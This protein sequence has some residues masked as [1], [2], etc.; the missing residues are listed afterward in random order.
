MAKKEEYRISNQKFLEEMEKQEGIIKHRTGV[1]YKYLNKSD[2][3]KSPN[4]RNIVTVHYRGTLIN[5]REFDSSLKKPC[6]EAFR[7]RDLIDGWKIVLQQMHI[8]DKVIAYIP[9]EYGYGDRTV[10]A[11]PA[12]STLIFEIELLGI[13]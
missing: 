12:F 6:P 13:N 4:V 5:G 1:L 9:Y 2:N 8:G 7:L 3:D 11:I 10:G